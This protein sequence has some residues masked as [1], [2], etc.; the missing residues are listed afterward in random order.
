M[1]EM[2]G[3]LDEINGK[4]DIAEEKMLGLEDLQIGTIQNE[5]QRDKGTFFKM[6]KKKSLSCRI[7]SNSLI[8]M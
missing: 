2:R 1:S 4:L 8:Y 7:I 5:I 3:T 6:E